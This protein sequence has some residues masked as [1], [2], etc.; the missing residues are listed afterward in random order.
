[1]VSLLIECVNILNWIHYSCYSCCLLCWLPYTMDSY[2]DVIHNCPNCHV[3][4]GRYVRPPC[5]VARSGGGT[6]GFRTS[7]SNSRSHFSHNRSRVGGIS[8][9][10]ISHH[11]NSSIHGFHHSSAFGSHNRSRISHSSSRSHTH[12][13]GGMSTSKKSRTSRRRWLQ[14]FRLSRALTEIN[15]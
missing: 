6:S 1:M 9:H 15:A 3:E 11:N 13:T 4:C 10:G 8:H 5:F 14:L 12:R 7:G 2:K